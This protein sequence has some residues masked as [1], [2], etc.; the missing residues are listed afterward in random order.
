MEAMPAT[1]PGNA[2]PPLVP[3]EIPVRASVREND[4]PVAFTAGHH[5]TATGDADLRELAESA[6]APLSVIVQVTKRCDFGCVFCS[7]TLMMPGRAV[8]AGTSQLSPDRLQAL[9]QRIYPLTGRKSQDGT[10][11][12]LRPVEFPD[13]QPGRRELDLSQHAQFEAVVLALLG[14]GRI[15]LRCALEFGDRIVLGA[16]DL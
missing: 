12:R 9:R 8:I 2:D 4:G 15:E 3:P 1:S 6:S 14:P 7:E 5:F 16:G 13:S 10:E 11:R